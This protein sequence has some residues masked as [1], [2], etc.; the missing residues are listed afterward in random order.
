MRH[1]LSQQ[2]DVVIYI[3]DLLSKTNPHITKNVRDVSKKTFNALNDKSIDSVLS[4]CEV[5][6]EKRIWTYSL[7]AYDFAYRVKKAYTLQTFDVFEQWLFSYIEDWG[8]CDD[9]CTHAFGSL[10]SMYNELFED[11]IKWTTHQRFSVRRAAAVILIHPIKYHHDIKIDPFII[12]DKLMS[13]PHYL[14]QKGYGWMLKVLSQKDPKVVV[15]YLE[16]NHDIMTRTA[17]RY[18]LEKL[19]DATKKKLMKL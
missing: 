12:S 13:D 16:K 14:V 2:K 4:I 5:L 9:F 18:A 1:S 10:L 6:L 17:Y 8:D 19:D 7:I 15:E 11:V 3:D